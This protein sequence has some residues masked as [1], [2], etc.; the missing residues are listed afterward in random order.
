MP[1]GQSL[2]LAFESL[3]READG[4]ADRRASETTRV[5]AVEQLR[6]RQAEACARRVDASTALTVAEAGS[7]E[8][9]A[10]W[11]SLWAKLDIAA[12]TPAVMREWQRR[13]EAVLTALGRARQAAS[14]LADTKARH[15]AAYAALAALLPCEA[16]EAGATVAPLLRAANRLARTR[17]EQAA[18]RSKA[19]ALADA[20]RTAAA[21]A[22]RA[23]DTVGEELSAWRVGWATHAAAL[24]LAADAPAESGTLALEL[25]SRVEAEARAWRDAHDR[26]ADISLAVD[27]FVAE[28]AAIARR[29]APQLAEA[30]CLDAVRALAGRLATARADATRHAELTAARRQQ[31]E[32]IATLRQHDDEADAALAAL[33]GLAGV[34]DDAALQAAIARAAA[35]ATLSAE[36][37]AREAELM[38]LGDGLAL[39]EL[40]A[41]AAGVDPDALPGRI[42]A[43]GERLRLIGGENEA[44]AGKLAGLGATL[45]A[46]EGGH[47]AAGAAQA[48]RDAVAEAQDIA[49][50]YV[51][52]RLAQ[53]LLR[54]G[55]DRFRREQQAPLLSR[56]SQ[57]FARLTEGRYDRLS[58]D[59]GED[60]RCVI[61]ALRPDDTHCPAERLSEGTRDQLYLA[62]RL[63]AIE[64]EVGAS[65]PLPFIADDLLVNFDDHRARA[66]LRVLA[67]FART[68]Q[69]I[70]FTHHAHIAD[71]A[72]PGLASLHTLPATE[73]LVAA[74]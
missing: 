57:L 60:D 8:R 49:G 27:S 47:D 3:L 48:M 64:G 46:M 69:T 61:L 50:R 42:A 2:E 54:A 66:A 56:A 63:A 37:A 7:A 32:T 71:M 62:L 68:T 53:T 58:V 20:A 6:S 11:Q 44:Y 14:G 51:R 65:E 15:R 29:V 23:C 12:Q 17:E 38:S 13:R 73:M 26:I 9:R 43:I 10:A 45:E 5:V 4:L 25:W 59:A 72:E 36:I 30:E 24:G 28:A 40:E 41:E 16:A 31:H 70:L 52:L 19:A 39:A 34:D 21:S 22:A 18:A 33:R 1:S 55:I 67:E 35:H 74:Q